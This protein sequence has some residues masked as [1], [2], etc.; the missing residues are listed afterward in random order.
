MKYK[1]GD[2]CEISSS[3]RIF[4]NEYRNQGIPFYRGKEII[5]KSKGNKVSTEIFIEKK[6]YE[7]IKKKFSI[8]KEGDILLSSVGTLGVPWLVENEE[9]YFKDGNLTWISN[10]KDINNKFLY[11]W[12]LSSYGQNQIYAKAIGS[13]Q[14][15][16]TIEILKGFELDLPSV[17]YQK[18]AS[19]LLSLIDKK[20]IN[21]RNLNDNLAELKATLFKAWFVEFVDEE[22][23]INTDSGC[24]PIN[25]KVGTF[26]E[27]IDKTIG[28]D[29]GKE[30]PEGNYTE[31]VYC[32][33]GADI[34]EVKAGNK[35]KMPIRYIL[36]KNF[37]N[38][39]LEEN[40][41]VIE[42]SGGSP[43]QSTGRITE[44][45]SYLLKRYDK[46][47]I[48]TNF[49]RA[50]KPKYGYSSFIYS[51]W[52]YLYDKGI[53][54]SYENG[55]TG[56]KNLDINSLIENEQIVIP[57]KD[58]VEVFNKVVAQLNGM[59][60]SNGLENEKLSNLRD[61]LLP[62]L[63]SGEMDLGNIEFDAL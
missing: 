45:S 51:Y 9:F 60:Y 15:A 10:F 13:T 6:R 49:C 16:L 37:T 14:K 27:I 35:G 30:S 42:I 17:E 52:Q 4:A 40:D 21:N 56:I 61:Q 22:R 20:I 54:F 31:E 1:L 58:K 50:I 34:P 39:G 57:P 23:L 28:G 19:S 7:E 55:T 2:L 3:K 29:W 43:T 47:M 41:L 63:L 12:L 5:E 33:R 8:P 25:W 38:K 32:I 59:I 62:K 26:S 44:I 53:M 18:K 11:Y 24:I 36:P 46:G 48:C